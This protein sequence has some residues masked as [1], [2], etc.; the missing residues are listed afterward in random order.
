MQKMSSLSCNLV[1]S[2]RIFLC[3]RAMFSKNMPIVNPFLSHHHRIA[4][5][6][7]SWC[8]R[9]VIAM[10]RPRPPDDLIRASRF[11]VISP[12][13]NKVFVRCLPFICK[14]AIL[15]CHIVC[16]FVGHWCKTQCETNYGG[17][18]LVRSSV[19]R[20]NLSNQRPLCPILFT[21][22]PLSF[23]A[24]AQQPPHIIFRLST[25]P[26]IYYIIGVLPLFSL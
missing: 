19:I 23:Y 15:K 21:F 18:P 6:K 22:Q 24:S 1:F 8:L 16:I 17:N 2:K 10:T 12:L 26:Y 25:V 4:F 20:V 5:P 3:L 13:Q 9:Q 14:C 7:S 11:S